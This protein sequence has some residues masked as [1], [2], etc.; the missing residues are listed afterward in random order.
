MEKGYSLVELLAVLSLFLLSFTLVLPNLGELVIR[1]EAEKL[2]NMIQRDL[3][4]ALHYADTHQRSL[5][6]QFHPQIHLY[7]VQDGNQILLQRTYPSRFR[8][9]TNFGQYD[10]FWIYANGT[11]EKGGT[12]TI[13]DRNKILYRLYVQL[14]TGSVREEVR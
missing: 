1:Y 8:I 9:E 7:V 4:W 5:S 14:V 2:K 11:V 3:N 12:I 13:K 10:Q 6:F